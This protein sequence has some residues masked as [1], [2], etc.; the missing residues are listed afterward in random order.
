VFWFSVI[1]PK[2]YY[3]VIL[4]R[5]LTGAG[6]IYICNDRMTEMYMLYPSSFMCNHIFFNAKTK[7]HPGMLTMED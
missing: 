3:I 5:T 4:L 7:V 2:L 6:A 1:I